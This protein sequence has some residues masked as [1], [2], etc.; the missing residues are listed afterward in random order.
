M[1]RGPTVYH[2]IWV[3][4]VLHV[5]R[6]GT[7]PH[8]APDDALVR[9][10]AKVEPGPLLGAG[11]DVDGSAAAGLA[12]DLAREVDILLKGLRPISPADPQLLGLLAV[13]PLVTLPRLQLVPLGL[14]CLALARDLL[15]PVADDVEGHAARDGVDQP[16]LLLGQAGD[17]DV[18]QM[19]QLRAPGLD[20][21][22]V[23]VLRGQVRCEGLGREGRPQRLKRPKIGTVRARGPARAIRSRDL[24]AAAASAG[25]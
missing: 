19:L 23:G 8:G 6:D 24:P 15:Q 3:L 5:G 21:A 12:Q 25:W 4:V 20:L 22:L 14:G 18:G 17:Y 16:L 11:L 1:R 13:G 2:W 10:E 9:R 7:W